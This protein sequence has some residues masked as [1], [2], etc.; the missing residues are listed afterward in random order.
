MTSIDQSE[1]S[2][3]PDSHLDP[4][5]LPGGVGQSVLGAGSPLSPL[6]LSGQL[7]RLSRHSPDG[8]MFSFASVLGFKLASIMVIGRC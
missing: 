2:V 3:S 8:E 5:P 6:L 4:H 1:T 7:P